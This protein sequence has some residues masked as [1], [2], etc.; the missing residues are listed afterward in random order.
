MGR[1]LSLSLLTK[2]PRRQLVG[3]KREQEILDRLTAAALGGRGGA[4]VLHGEPGIGKSA[5]LEYSVEAG[6]AF[7]IVRT[8]GVEGEMELPYAALFQL[9]SSSF[10]LIPQL[11]D[12]QRNA[13][14]VA[15]GLSAG[16]AP[17]PLLVGLAVLGLFSK[18]AEKQPL[19]CMV[20]DA[21]WLD[22]ESGRALGF[23]ARRLLADRI[24]LI[25]AARD[26]EGIL[27]GLPELQ[28]AAL[29][30][31]DSRAILRS[32]MPARL[33]E[34]VLGRIIAETHGNPLA[35]FE[36][37]RGLTP[38]QLAGGFGL[39][40][41]QQP[42][43]DRIQ[44]NFARRF[45]QVPRDARRFALV[46]SADPLGDPA[47][48]LRAAQMLGISEDSAH[49]PELVGVLSFGTEV[50]FAHPL[51]RSAV[52]RAFGSD[53]QAEVHRALADATDPDIDPDR[54]A[55]H[56]AQ[57]TRLPDEEV[58][59]DLERSASRAQARGGFA[60]A[61]AFLERSAVL[62]VN[63]TQRTRRALLAADAKRQ[64]GAFDP[65][66]RLAAMA[67]RGPLEE[68]QRAEL[69]LLRARISF[70]NGRGRESPPLF[71]K[72]AGRL[73]PID[74]RRASDAYLDA[75]TAAMFAGRLTNGTTTV[76]VAHA[77]LKAPRPAPLRGSDL[78]LAGL[79]RTIT[80]G[81]AAGTP[82]LKKAVAAF[83][84]EAVVP[85]EHLPWLWLAGRAA[86]F[87][88][89][90]DAWDAFTARQVQIIRDEGALTG[91]PLTLSTRVGVHLFAGE[92]ATAASLLD[93]LEAVVEVTENR[94]VP[95]GP[96]A[97]AA[98]RGHGDQLRT[99]IEAS[100][101]DIVDR[102][103]G[104]A[105]SMARWATAVLCNA[106]GRYGEA[107]SAAT[108][109]LENPNELWFSPWATVELIE[110]A[111][112]TKNRSAAKPALDRL[113]QGTDASGTEWALAVQARCRA[114]LSDGKAAEDLYREAIDRL[115]PTPL[116][117]EIARA[118]LLYGEWLRRERRQRD[119]REPLRAALEL[120]SEFGM[121][122]FAGRAEAELRA[123]GEKARKRTNEARYELTPQE[124][125]ISVLAAH[126][127]TNREIA[128]QLYISLAT[129]QYHLSKVYSKYGVKGRAQLARHLLQFSEPAGEHIEGLDPA[130]GSQDP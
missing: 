9:C 105:L 130:V 118:H 110:A 128:A 41:A 63:P 39:P 107:F 17:D 23:V 15:F 99:L 7:R 116:R 117:F 67:E 127:S 43:S 49:Q 20:D 16:V 80:D 34:G 6:K 108:D 40:T 126:G 11:P 4:L 56:R 84:D 111:S 97:V 58:A 1:D 24:A 48:V 66:L 19:L 33:D 73:A 18:A 54:R 76:E 29:G 121:E 106:T 83:R 109:A 22:R 68:S 51:F 124:E 85:G 65:S 47:L 104:M 102:G 59:I 53:E 101:K 62:T 69:D 37:P 60:A 100:V 14:S 30:D 36:L 112:R 125:R 115:K 87:I 45:A 129:V 3:R 122:G 28:V 86:A 50:S 77:A 27:D 46:A 61:A 79:A 88:W 12:D 94:A 71:L 26:V 31:R 89:D 25:F 91:L 120:F 52:Y 98:F 81:S 119:S 13:L 74:A 78:L 92:L 35:L 32:V 2:S 8:G 75:L 123:T 10:D 72:A 55:W 93:E 113:A 90:Y 5:L 82:I 38:A 57:A 21:Q 42:L 70:A 103:E 44:E 114:L 64:L 96:L 95:N